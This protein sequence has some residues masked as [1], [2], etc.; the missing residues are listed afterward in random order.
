MIISQIHDRWFR[1]EED[2]IEDEKALMHE[3]EASNETIE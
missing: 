2:I 1:T 3:I